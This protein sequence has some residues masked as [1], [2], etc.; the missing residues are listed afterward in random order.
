MLCRKWPDGI[1]ERISVGKSV[2]ARE[3]FAD[4]GRR[5]HYGKNTF[6]ASW[7]RVSQRPRM[8]F[9]S[10]QRVASRCAAQSLR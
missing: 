6:V 8:T 10:V 3:F 2:Q 9:N 5:E 1:E 4:I 7:R